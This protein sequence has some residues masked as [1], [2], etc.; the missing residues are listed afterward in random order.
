MITDDTAEEPA[1]EVEIEKEEEK[2]EEG[3][4]EVLATPADKPEVKNGQPPPLPPRR[5]NV[6]SVILATELSTGTQNVS[7]TVPSGSTRMVTTSKLSP[8][9]LKMR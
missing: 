3:A 7:A 9:P 4:G 6:G 8:R 1:L 5:E 2:E